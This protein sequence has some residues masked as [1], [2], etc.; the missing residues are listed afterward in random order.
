MDQPVNA[1]T[2]TLRPMRTSDLDE[3]LPYEDELFGT[4]SWSRQ[5]YLDELADTELRQYLV[6]EQDGTVVGSAGL[7]VIGETAQILTVGV[8]PAARRQGIGERL[9]QALLAEAV[10]RRASEVLLEVRMDNAAARQLYTKLGFAV[11]GTRRG[12]YDQGRMDA[13]VMRRA[14]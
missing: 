7:L 6:A 8:L 13:V 14:L 10:R 12:Y 1:S 4:E 9:V 2:V 3:L 11:I 5:S